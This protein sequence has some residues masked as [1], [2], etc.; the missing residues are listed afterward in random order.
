MDDL[1]GLVARYH[2]GIDA[3]YQIS[4]PHTSGYIVDGI[5]DGIG[6]IVFWFAV[7]LYSNNRQN[8]SKSNVLLSSSTYSLLQSPQPTNYYKRRLIKHYLLLLAQ[9]ALSSLFWNLFLIKYHRLLDPNLS[10][11]FATRTPLQDEIFKSSLLFT[12]MWLWRCLN[13]HALTCY[14]LVAV[15]LN[16]QT[17][18]AK[19]SSQYFFW[20][21]LGTSFLCEVHFQDIKYRLDTTY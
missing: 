7:L 9:M 21:I 15:W 5:C 11:G 3:R 6:F 18:Y 10:P 13:P 20:V 14:F 2:I 8:A 12:I 19:R 1:D 16:Q 4:M 17:Q